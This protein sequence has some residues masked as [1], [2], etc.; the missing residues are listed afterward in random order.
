MDR[1]LFF[2]ATMCFF[3]VVGFFMQNI[4]IFPPLF[5]FQVGSFLKSP[6]FPIWILGSET[7]LSVF[8]TKASSAHFSQSKHVC[9]SHTHFILN[10]TRS[11]EPLQVRK[12]KIW[13]A[14]KRLMIAP[15]RQS[16]WL[17]KEQERGGRDGYSHIWLFFFLGFHL[18]KY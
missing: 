18:S 8:F 15:L 10:V 5:G 11:V 9:Q 1:H 2:K 6:K 3:F 7:H 12:T 13:N 17:K 4:Y 14:R 16:F